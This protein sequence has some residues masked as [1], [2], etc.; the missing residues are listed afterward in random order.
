MDGPRI[1]I[2]ITIFLLSAILAPVAYPQEMRKTIVV[3]SAFNANNPAIR[4]V[5]EG[6][7]H[8]LSEENYNIVVEPLDFARFPENDHVRRIVTLYNEKQKVTPADLL[9]LFGPLVFKE[10][11]SNGLKILDNTPTIIIDNEGMSGDS[12]HAPLSE[13][14]IR[15]NL[16]YNCNKTLQTA[17]ELFPHNKD[18]YVISG[19]AGIDNYFT[20][21]VRKETRYFNETHNFIYVSGISMDSTLRFVDRI[22]RNSIVLVTNYQMD[23]NMISYSTPEVIFIVDQHSKAPVFML[24]E[25]FGVNK[26]GVGGYV[27][28]YY[29]VGKETGRIAKQ[30]LKGTPIKDITVNKDRFYRYAYDWQELKKW[31]LVNSRLIPGD[32]IFY[33]EPFLLKYKKYALGM[34]LFL[35]AIIM[36][37]VYLIG[38]NKRLKMLGERILETEKMYRELIREDRMAKMTELTASLSHELN[39]PLTAILFSAQAGKRFLQSGKLDQA[40]AGQILDN[41]IEDDKRAGGIISSVRSLMKLEHREKEKIDLNEAIRETADI[42][43]ND[44]VRQKIKLVI[45]CD[46]ERA[47][48]LADK[49][50]LQQ[51]LM[52]F[53]RNAEIAMEKTDP[54][55]KKLEV[56]SV[57]GK[58]FVTVSV[59]DS[60]PGIDSAIKEKIFEPFVTTRKGGTGIGLALSRSIIESHNGTIWAENMPDGGADFSFRLNL[61]KNG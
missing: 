25:T 1:K 61:L 2:A 53:I 28:S 49:I 52:N 51:V 50:Q 26:G 42:F 7:R 31:G 5:I 39:Q 19:V 55:N 54:A 38:R 8:E 16:E 24:P 11:K 9:V 58:D 59:R 37:V 6:A 14:Q 3:F 23:I 13:N 45:K 48:V 17:F 60:G 56:I 33:N 57:V 29:E 12:V 18:V 27:F 20:E 15:F 36:L 41:I 10:L 34:S 40:Q 21:L 46:P 47:Y 35:G 22:P 30:I 4:I 43:Y 32:S 44:A